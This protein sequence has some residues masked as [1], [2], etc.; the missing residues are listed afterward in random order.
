MSQH[1]GAIGVSKVTSMLLEQGFLVNQPMY[2]NGYDLITDYRGHL[3]R[4]QIKSTGQS[5]E[6]RNRQKLKFSAVRGPGAAA[7]LP[8]TI[9]AKG[10]VDVFIFFHT[11]HNALFVIP[12]E[13]LPRT[14]SVYFAPNCE[15]RDNWDVLRTPKKG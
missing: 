5:E 14:M 12:A 15:W 10:V 1:L 7:C 11:K 4:V 2:D 9:Y 6:G 13:K 8:K 3:K